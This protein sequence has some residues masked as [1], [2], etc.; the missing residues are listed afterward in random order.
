MAMTLSVLRA[1]SGILLAALL[2][3]AGNYFGDWGF[4][5]GAGKAVMSGVGFVLVLFLAIFQPRIERE[6][7]VRREAQLEVE[8]ERE[9]TRDKSNDEVESEKLRRAIGMSPNKSLERTREG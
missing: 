1:A 6:I 3:A 2:F 5:G 9:R 7:H 8:R 4:F